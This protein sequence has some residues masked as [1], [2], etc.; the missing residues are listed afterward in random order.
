MF[1]YECEAELLRQEIKETVKEGDPRSTNLG[2]SRFN[3]S[4]CCCSS[5]TTQQWW[6]PS[7]SLHDSPI[8]WTEHH[9]RRKIPV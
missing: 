1:K 3:L 8:I 4:E 7:S 5:C 9:R 6:S 2:R